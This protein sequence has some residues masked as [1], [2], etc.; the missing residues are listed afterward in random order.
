MSETRT[1]HDSLGDIEVP[2]NRAMP[3]GEGP[4]PV[5]LVI[6]EI[7]GVHDRPSYRKDQATDGFARMLA[8][9]KAHGAF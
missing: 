8:W 7:F 3:Q 1:E 4:F 2:A 6:Q 9:F 5:V